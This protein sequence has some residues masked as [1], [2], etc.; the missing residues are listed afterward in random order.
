MAALPDE[1]ELP[2]VTVCIH[3]HGAYNGSMFKIP[4]GIHVNIL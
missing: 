4:N 3:K 1:P 2:E